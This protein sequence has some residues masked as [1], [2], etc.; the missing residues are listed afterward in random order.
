[1]SAVE[2]NL[3]ETF[4]GVDAQHLNYQRKTTQGL[5]PLLYISWM[6]SGASLGIFTIVQNISI[7]IIVQPH[8][9]GALCAVIFCQMLYYDKGYRWYSAVG[10]F[11]LYA[12]A[13]SGFEVGMV[14]AS[15]FVEHHH[16]SDGLTMLWGILS[17]IFLFVGFVPQFIEIYKAREVYAL[18]YL[19]LAMDSLGAVFSIMSLAFKDSFDGIAFAGYAVV[20]LA[21]IVIFL[22]ALVLNPRARRTRAQLGSEPGSCDSSCAKAGPP[23][24]K[25]DVEAQRAGAGAAEGVGLPVKVEPARAA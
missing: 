18:S 8:C 16:H 9:Y 11:L 12:I 22:L 13:C 19:F 2:L 6:L 3:A 7:P 4:H 21:E 20:L 15:R 5:A 1:M 10:A 25:V 17:D 23:L 14:Y 24:G